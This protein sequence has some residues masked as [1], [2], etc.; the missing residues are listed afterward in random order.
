MGGNEEQWRFWNEVAG[1]FWVAAQQELEHHTAPFGEAALRA[2]AVVS[3]ERVLDVGCGCGASSLALAAAVGPTGRVDGVDLSE[4]MLARARE[5]AAAA[6]LDQLGFRQLDAQTGEFGPDPYDVVFSR[7]GVMFFADPVAAFT[8]LRGALRP[9]VGRCVFACWQPPSQN[10]WLALP[11]RAVMRLFDLA[12]PPHDAPG[13]F[14]L[15][16][17]D[18]TA[19]VLT[20]A[21]FTGVTSEP[22]SCEVT[23]A[24][25]ADLEGWAH[26]RLVMGPARDAYL[27]TDVAAQAHARAVVRETVEPYGDGEAIRMGAAGWIVTARTAALRGV[28]T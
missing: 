25:Q 19:A 9:G 21:G 18:R 22:Y 28:A 13:P 11:N 23:V 17:P 14:S 12:P 8:R 7:F 10:P 4:V 3:G 5:Q 27:G 20:E 15:S 6:G 26:Q 1:P 24:R 16:D 2:A